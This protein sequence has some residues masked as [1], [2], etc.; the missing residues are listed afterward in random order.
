LGRAD[1]T[2]DETSLRFDDFSQRWLLLYVRPKTEDTALCRRLV[3]IK[4][5]R[6]PW[7]ASLC[8]SPRGMADMAGRFL[9]VRKFIHEKASG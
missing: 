5:V 6:I 9:T 8:D 4:E 3:A 2:V 1:E 7:T